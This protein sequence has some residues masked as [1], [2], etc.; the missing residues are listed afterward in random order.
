MDARKLGAGAVGGIAGGIVFGALMQM[1]GMIEMIGGLV[2]REDAAV[3]WVVHLV[4]ATI[5]GLGYAV[6]FGQLPQGYGK[7]AVF[8]LLYGAIW[9]VLGPLVLMPLFMGMKPFPSIQQP[10]IMS[11]MGH[12]LYGLVLGFVFVA[13]A[14]RARPGERAAVH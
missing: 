6:T 12:L 13:V 2:G 1:M 10:Q 11:L 7:G 4:I 3:G 8:G 5:I 9:W 14:S